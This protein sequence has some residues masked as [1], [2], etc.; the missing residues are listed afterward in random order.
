MIPESRTFA[1]APLLS[2]LPFPSQVARDYG[3]GN[4]GGQPGGSPRTAAAEQPLPLLVC[5]D[6]LLRP[7]LEIEAGAVRDEAETGV[8]Q[9]TTTF[10]LQHR[11]E[12][13]AQ[14]VQPQHISGSVLA[15]FRSKGL[16]TP[17]G[18]LLLFRQLDPQE[19]P[20]QI[21]EAVPIG[22]GAYQSGG[23]LG[24]V[25][26]DTHHPEPQIQYPNVE[27]G[28]MKQLDDPFVGQQCLEIGRC[29]GG[30]PG[31][32]RRREVHEMAYPVAGGQLYQTEA[33]TVWIEAGR[34]RVDGDARAERRIGRQIAMV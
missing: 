2:A 30:A 13:L 12:L 33:V 17:V 11:V 34:L 5:E 31:P 14:S 25:D 4:G 26:R 27:S 7:S 32:T 19:L 9:V 24:A 10:P 1:S 22:V 6:V 8:R 20:T 23:D 29:V 16:G 18:A 21:L 28:E 15:L 3:V